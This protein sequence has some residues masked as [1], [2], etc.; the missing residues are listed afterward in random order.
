VETI[1]VAGLEIL[2]VRTGARWKQNCY[3]VRDVASG[4]QLVIDPGADVETIAR[5][6]DPAF[7]VKAVL[8]THAHYDHLGAAGALCV[9]YGIDCHVHAQDVR[10][11][12]LAPAYALSFEQVAIQAPT[13]IRSF[14]SQAIFEV[15]SSRLE[16]ISTPGHTPGSVCFRTQGVLFTGDTLFNA[17]VGRTDLPGGNRAALKESIASL[18][19]SCT[20]EAVILPGHG[21]FWNTTEAREWWRSPQAEDA[22]PWSAAHA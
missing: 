1:H 4:E 13:A 14:D 8:L 18:L 9:E 22:F 19:L 10:L 20:L 17:R 11:V 6:I 5:A 7:P 16:V 2:C 3:V 21:R 12:H 15:G